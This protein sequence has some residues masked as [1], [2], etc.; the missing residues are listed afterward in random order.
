M[1]RS[2][3]DCRTSG[4]I[5]SAFNFFFFD[6]QFVIAESY[7]HIGTHVLS[8]YVVSVISVEKIHPLDNKLPKNQ[9]QGTGRHVP[10]NNARENSAA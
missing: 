4:T 7:R 2:R 6:V 3:G 5:I 10:W 8:T 1:H 9:A